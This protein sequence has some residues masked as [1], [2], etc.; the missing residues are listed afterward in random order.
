MKA[1][2]MFN[3]CVQ[4]Q[5]ISHDLWSLSMSRSFSLLNSSIVDY[6][7][8]IYDYSKSPHHDDKFIQYFWCKFLVFEL[9]SGSNIDK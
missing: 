5:P 7:S 3:P 9:G 6:M 8:L 4:E 2:Q 1:A